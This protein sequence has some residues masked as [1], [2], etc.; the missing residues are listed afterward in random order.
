MLI[1]THMIQTTT[2]PAGDSGVGGTAL[3]A[4]QGSGSGSSNNVVPSFEGKGPLLRHLLGTEAAYVER[5]RGFKVR[6]R[7]LVCI[8]YI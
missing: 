2:I 3:A 1:L 6:G 7:Y 8:L 4:A 5:L